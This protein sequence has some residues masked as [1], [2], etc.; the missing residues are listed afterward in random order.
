[1]TSKQPSNTNNISQNASQFN[2][3]TKNHASQFFS[4]QKLIRMFIVMTLQNIEAKDLR[5]TKKPIFLKSRTFCTRIFF[6]LVPS[7]TGL[8]RS[9]KEKNACK[10]QKQK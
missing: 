5:T 6:N 10:T 1:M 4:R 9:S 2:P 8:F 3:S 7:G